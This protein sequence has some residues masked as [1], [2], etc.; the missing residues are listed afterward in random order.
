MEA[1]DVVKAAQFPAEGAFVR[2][3]YR[4]RDRIS[5]DIS[6]DFEAQFSAFHRSGAPDL[7]PLA[8]RAT[9]HHFDHLS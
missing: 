1:H 2:Q 5:A 8:L 7:Y 6:I 9:P 4:F 3:R